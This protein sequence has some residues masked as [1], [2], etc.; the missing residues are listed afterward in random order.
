MN[1]TPEELQYILSAIDGYV[2]ANG[3]NVAATGLGIV[4]KIKA[5]TTSVQTT[6]TLDDD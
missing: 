5:A 3:I 4:A 2:R 6:E 1:L